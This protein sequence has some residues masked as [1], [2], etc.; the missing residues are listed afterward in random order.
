MAKKTI[1]TGTGS[2]VNKT[3]KK[4]PTTTK[5]T[6]GTATITKKKTLTKEAQLDKENIKETVK[7]IVTT[8]RE[9]KYK[10]P[11]E[12]NNTLDRKAWRSKVRSKLRQYESKIMKATDEKEKAK[13]EKSYNAYRK[14]VLSVS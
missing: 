2:T 6:T 3:T 14:E 12:V 11:E 8:E 1:K 10:Y 7:Q 9:V 5:K 4:A 13:L